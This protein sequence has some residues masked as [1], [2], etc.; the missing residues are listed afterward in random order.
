MILHDMQ[1]TLTEI[2]DST[3]KKTKRRTEGTVTMTMT[4]CLHTGTPYILNSTTLTA[5]FHKFTILQEWK[6]LSFSQLAHSPIVLSRRKQKKIRW[7]DLRRRYNGTISS[8]SCCCTR[9][10]A[11]FLNQVMKCTFATATIMLASTFFVA[12]RRTAAFTPVVSHRAFSRTSSLAMSDASNPIVYFDMEVGGND[13]G[14]VTFELRADVVPKTGTW[15]SLDYFVDGP[16]L[17]CTRT[18]LSNLQLDIIGISRKQ[19]IWLGISRKQ[20]KISSCACKRVFSLF[21][22]FRIDLC[23]LNSNIHNSGKFPC[24]VYWGTRI[25]I[26]RIVI[27]SCH[28]TI[29]VPRR[30]LYQPQ[31]NRWKEYLWKQIQWRELHIETCRERNFV[32]GQRWSQQY[33]HFVFI[34]YLSRRILYLVCLKPHLL[35]DYHNCTVAW[36]VSQWVAILYLYCWYSMARRQAC[37]VR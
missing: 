19:T 13:V 8:I 5:N 30:W 29:Y 14:R 22:F 35:F 7:S 4:L 15:L 37:C 20:T 3:S 23:Y 27:P 17:I 16:C 33:V 34:F 24:L 11:T 31:R 6:I 21:N 9:N 10:K 12:S 32:N 18:T 26:Q 25:R 1:L 28:S 2:E 36:Y